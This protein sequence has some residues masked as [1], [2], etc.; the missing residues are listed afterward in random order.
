MHKKNV[1]ARGY[2]EI[3]TLRK[4]AMPL[5]IFQNFIGAVI[6]FVNIWFPARIIDVLG[7]TKN[8][9]ELSLYIGTAAFLNA[10]FFLINTWLNRKNESAIDF[11]WAHEQN[12]V[13]RKLYKI[14]YHHLEDAEFFSKVGR[15][16]D[17]VRTSMGI[18]ATLTSMLKTFVSVATRIATSLFLGF[19]FFVFMFRRTGTSFWESPWLALVIVVGIGIFI[20]VF[21]PLTNVVNKRSVDIRRQYLDIYHIFGYYCDMLSD[22]KSGKEIR[23][24]KEQ[25]FIT[26]HATKEMVEK[27]IRLEKQRGRMLAFNN[28]LMTFSMS[29]VGFA[30]YLIIG[31]KAMAGLYS[32]G[33]IVLYIGACFQI[34]KAIS[35]G[36]SVFGQLNSIKPRM[37]LYY[38]IL[39]T[40]NQDSIE[41]DVP[42]RKSYDIKCEN[43]SFR[44]KDDLPFAIKNINL[45][46]NQ[47]E[48]IAIVGENGS[49]KT[50]FV[51]LLCRLY[52]VTN[53]EFLLGNK[54]IAFYDQEEYR[55]LF[56]VVF[57][58]YQIFSLPLGENVAATQDVDQAFALE[59]LKKA[60]FG[61]RYGLD[62][63]IYKD[64]DK[65]G[66]E[67]SG[68]ESQKI[69]L[70]RALYKD[71]P[72][73]ILDEP[74]SAL[75]PFA[76]AEI[77]S[78]IDELTQD[79]TVIYISHRLSSCCFCDK[80]AVFEN[81][82]IV[83]H[84]THKELL[85]DE[86]GKYFKLWSAQA[87]YYA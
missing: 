28:G 35:D 52:Q 44:Y 27:G 21:F 10:V 12:S 79:K 72:I 55:K 68:G 38:E 39:D 8:I 20:A 7:D 11:F 77:Y 50:T 32:I 2:R 61:D 54:S 30:V 51:K 42:E 63:Y 58:D 45:I 57:Q 84:G 1:I 85:K 78:K 62:Q 24:F 37:Q 3:W 81:G 65:D 46:I 43:V 19:P 76:E 80:I 74:T 67:I 69:A 40:P 22:Y 53:G 49:G 36:V 26:K 9:K 47:G 33:S 64:C 23:L 82:Q 48:K 18:F 6:P 31:L 73:I 5:M 29:F 56:S 25:D 15:H 16:V 41:G 4:S 59:C 70:A 13:S 17:D 86:N 14:N 87:K 83:Q 60:G 66:I 75:D 71:A 34:V